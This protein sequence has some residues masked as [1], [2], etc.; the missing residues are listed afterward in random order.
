MNTTQTALPPESRSS[1]WQRSTLRRLLVWLGR[2]QTLRRLLFVCVALVTLIALVYGIANWRAAR[3]LNNYKR[4]L[5][6]QGEQL[7]WKSLIPP[8]VPDGQNFAMT[9]FLAPLFDFKTDRKLGEIKWRD[10]NA[11]NRVFNF[12]RNLPDGTRL[13]EAGRKA[14]LGNWLAQY[15][16][17]Q[18]NVPPAQLAL[19]NKEADR[20]AAARMI[21]TALQEYEPVVEELRHASTRPYARFNINYLEENPFSILLPHLAA[22]KKIARVLDMRA[23]AALALGQTD[24]AFADLKVMIALADSV[25]QEPL[26]ISQLVR[27]AS[28]PMGLGVFCEGAADHRWSEA[29]LKELQDGFQAIDLLGD[30]SHTLRG[31][32]GA[33][34]LTIQVLR[35][36]PNRGK[37]LSEIMSDNNNDSQYPVLALA[38]DVLLWL[39]PRGWFDWEQLNYLRDFQEYAQPMINVPLRQVNPAL[40]E[41]ADRQ[42]EAHS[43]LTLVSSIL[44]H[45]YFCRMLSPS[46]GNAHRRMA[47]GQTMVDQAAVVCALERYK[48]AKG[49]YPD[50]LAALAPQWIA[51]LPHDVIGGQPLK[52]QRTGDRFT[53]Y[54]VGWNQTDDGGTLELKPSGKQ[55]ELTS[56]DWVWPSF[57]Q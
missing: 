28:L 26:L 47:Y 6:A 45:R 16:K 46:L 49:Q 35:N 3:A 31:E 39:A 50:Q 54:S 13:W 52:Y 25:K 2:R 57:Q 8:P 44:Q 20:V 22:I 17:H 10:T 7:D 41:Q 29:Q 24:T 42:L 43:K 21:S 14:D 12:A 53:L 4:Q 33:V 19:T 27:L 18:S 9:P 55:I 48:L 1:M 38:R 40:S 30:Y 11:V 37:K 36:A 23:T 5:A 56:G 51:K 32:R 15:Y 34:C